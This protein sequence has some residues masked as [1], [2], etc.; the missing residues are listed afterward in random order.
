MEKIQHISVL[1]ELVYN[2]DI[3]LVGGTVRDMVI[4]K[5]PT[6]IDI[7][8]TCDAERFARTLADKIDGAP[9]LLDKSRGVF[10]VVSRDKSR[11]FYYDISLMR[12]EDIYAD[13]SLRDFTVD[14]M[15]IRLEDD[16]ESIIDPYNGQADIAKKCI[17]T[18]SQRSFEDDPLR[19]LRAFRLAGTLEFEIDTTT[20]HIIKEMASALRR[21]AKERIRDEFFRLLSSPT[22]IKYLRQM[23]EAGLL[24]V[25]LTIP[26]DTDI[27]KGMIVFEHLECL[28]N[29]L[30]TLFSPFDVNIGNYL[31]EKI[32][33]EITNAALWKWVSLFL[34]D[35]ITK[36]LIRMASR[37]L[38]LSNKACRL[39]HLAVEYLQPSLLEKGI[40]DKR[41]IYRF[42]KAAGNDGIGLILCQIASLSAVTDW[43]DRT[44]ENGKDAMAWYLREYKKMKDF[45][46]ITGDDL[47]VLF[48]IAHGPMFRYLLDIVEEGRAMGYIITKNDAVS[49]L[50]KLLTNV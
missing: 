21:A 2:T 50:K 14:A 38:R 29:T 9:F 33:N 12:G 15:A 3:Y 42:F 44:I 35:H 1:K 18:L 13:L 45:P 27:K 11:P 30:A 7:T 16:A 36:E 4:G 20:F 32:E 24:C 39:S 8:V 23:D 25:V 22:S 47:I 28:Y 5:E 31:Q 34:P 40:E 10:R 6:D 46:L 19:L 43:H 17:R 26:K 49:L 37:G 41:T 48:N